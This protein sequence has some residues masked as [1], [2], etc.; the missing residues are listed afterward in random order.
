ME[1]R[2][3][4]A[5]ID[6]VL[7]NIDTLIKM[8]VQFGICQISRLGLYL[9]YLKERYIQVYGH[10]PIENE[11]GYWWNYDLKFSNDIRQWY[12]PRIKFLQ[13]WKEDLLNN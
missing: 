10:P 13:D 12:E 3:I 4:I 1:K 9:F 5:V 7:L 6:D 8:N 2:E 11:D